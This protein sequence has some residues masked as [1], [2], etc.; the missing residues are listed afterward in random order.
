MIYIQDYNL[1]AILLKKNIYVY[2]IFVI[3]LIF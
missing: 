3:L 1:L 2:R